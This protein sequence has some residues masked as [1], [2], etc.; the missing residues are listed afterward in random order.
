MGTKK[1]R[2]LL[3]EPGLI[4]APGAYDAWSARLVELSGFPAVYMTGYGVSAS[5][6]GQPDIG[7]LTMSEMVT[8]A[9]NMA[10]AT[11]VP[12]IADADTGYGGTL[13][14]VRTVSEYELAGVSAIQIE[15]QLIP[16]RCGHMEGK[17]LIPLEDMITKIKAAAY[18]RKDPDFVIIARTDARAV[19]GFEQA[20]YRAQAYADAGAD[21]I[22]FEAPQSKDEMKRVAQTIPKPLLANM[23]EKGKTPLMTGQELEDLGYKIAIYPVASI[24]TVTK[25]ILTLLENLKTDDTTAGCLNNMI[26]FP[27]FNELIGLDKARGLEYSLARK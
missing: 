21:V 14:V 24:Y 15:D 18:A 23:V 10:V 12:I 3:N 16:K 8:Q 25:S 22:F 9:K 17:Q 4:R 26:D 2:Q 6:L 19:E 27:R 1:I 7:L 11:S 13:N 20:L 5:V